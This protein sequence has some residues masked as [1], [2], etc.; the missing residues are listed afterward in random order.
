VLA[1]LI[2]V[3]LWGVA[4]RYLLG[5]QAR[6]SEE[7]ARMLLVW[8]SVMGAAQAF[9]NAS[10][11]GM[12]ILVS[13]FD[14]RIAAHVAKF[15]LGLAIVFGLGLLVYGGGRFCLSTFQLGQHLV[16]LP[17]AKGWVY[18]CL[19]LAGLFITAFSIEE[20]LAP[21]T[22]QTEGARDA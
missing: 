11:L 1:L 13:K 6:W 10:H 22:Q 17:L 4:S 3:V 9:G 21:R 12:D 5:D 8:I 20:L 15:N 16:T 14:P 7:S 18:L 19:P 2:L